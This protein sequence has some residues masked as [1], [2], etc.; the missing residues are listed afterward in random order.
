MTICVIVIGEGISGVSPR[1][2]I[3]EVIRLSSQRWTK[4]RSTSLMK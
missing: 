2:G 1:V 3:N 4:K